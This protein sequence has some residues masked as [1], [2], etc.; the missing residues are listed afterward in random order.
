VPQAAILQAIGNAAAS[1][2][3]VIDGATRGS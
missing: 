2:S 3:G 1:L